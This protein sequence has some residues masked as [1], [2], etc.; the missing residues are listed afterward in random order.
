MF[1]SDSMRPLLL[2]MSLVLAA[3]AALP[4]PGC[5]PSDACLRHT[6]CDD[7]LACQ[8]GRCVAE[9]GAGGS[10]S[11]N[12]GMGGMSDGGMGGVS[13]GGMGGVADGGMGGAGGA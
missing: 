10:S 12:G 13:D 9:M 5:V 11:S 4:T 2:S 3:V 6:D 7:G 1:P 8:A